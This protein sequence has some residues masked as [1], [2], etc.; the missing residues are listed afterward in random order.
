VLLYLHCA[1]SVIGLVAVIMFPVSFLP[2]I[3]YHIAQLPVLFG[4]PCDEQSANK[5]AVVYKIKTTHYK[6]RNEYPCR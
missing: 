1:V 6:E 2:E 4:I 5:S 3:G